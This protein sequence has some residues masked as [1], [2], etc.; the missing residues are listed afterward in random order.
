MRLGRFPCAR[1]GGAKWRGAVSRK[2]SNK[3]VLEDTG[4][5]ESGC[6]HQGTEESV[7]TEGPTLSFLPIL[8]LVGNTLELEARAR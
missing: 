6:T 4:S 1:G 8:L 2:P 3:E 5:W 7:E